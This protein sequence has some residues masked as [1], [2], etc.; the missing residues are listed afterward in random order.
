MSQASSVLES[1]L[2]ADW[3][4]SKCL[5]SASETE[6]SECTITLESRCFDILNIFHKGNNPT[7]VEHT[8]MVPLPFK[9]SLSFGDSVLLWDRYLKHNHKLDQH[10][11]YN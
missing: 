4:F 9:H 8:L 1:K 6:L 7:N 10:I 5:H 2:P 3:A 11:F